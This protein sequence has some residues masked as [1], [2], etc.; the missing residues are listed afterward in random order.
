MP[1]HVR[2]DKTMIA[3]DNRLVLP[4]PES[5]VE[6]EIPH[7]DNCKLHG[8]AYENEA[9]DPRETVDPVDTEEAL[10]EAGSTKNQ[11]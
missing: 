5:R 7:T 9:H 10:Q 3:L 2:G 8:N 6:N 4:Q 1:A 11:P